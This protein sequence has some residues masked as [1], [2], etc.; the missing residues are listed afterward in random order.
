MCEGILKE[1]E[2]PILVGRPHPSLCAHFGVLLL[3]VGSPS[4]QGGF[5]PSAD[6]KA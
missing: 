1:S 2:G 3:V 5:A 6:G 4:V